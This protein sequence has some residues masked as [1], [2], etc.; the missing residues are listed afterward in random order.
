MLT[1][2]EIERMK[3]AYG[4]PFYRALMLARAEVEE[5]VKLLDDAMSEAACQA[6]NILEERGQN[7]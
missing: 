5:A 3:A 1:Q 4:S 7:A 6:H 2:Q